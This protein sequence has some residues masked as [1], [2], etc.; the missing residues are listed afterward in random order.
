MGEPIEITGIA[1]R[2]WN[3]A[4]HSVI[5]LGSALKMPRRRN[6][7]ARETGCGI[8]TWLRG[9]A[10]T[11]MYCWLKLYRAGK[12]RSTMTAELP[13]RTQITVN[14]AAQMIAVRRLRQVCTVVLGWKAQNVF[15]RSMQHQLCW[16]KPKKTPICRLR[17]ASVMHP[18]S[19]CLIAALRRSSLEIA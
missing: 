14:P 16:C 9:A 10:A 15:K 3:A 8:T 2:Q 7:S 17:C 13:P 4:T 11:D 18:E 12:C 6:T 19:L 5:T 1:E